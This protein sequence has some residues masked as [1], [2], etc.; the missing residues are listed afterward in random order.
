MYWEGT[1]GPPG[2]DFDKEKRQVCTPGILLLQCSVWWSDKYS[3]SMLSHDLFL[4]NQI[5]ISRTAGEQR[6][7]GRRTVRL[8]PSAE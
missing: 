1:G 6:E 8:L 4:V 2:P 5:G 7:G 3:F